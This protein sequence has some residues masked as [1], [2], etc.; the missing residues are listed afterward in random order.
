MNKVKWGV[1]GAGGIADRRTIPG[2][3]LADNAELT[4]IMEVNTALTEKLKQKYN[5]KYAYTD[6]LEL[7]ANP[8]IDAVYISSPV[9]YHKAQII[10]AAV[11]GKHI[12]CE[13]PIAMTIADC[14]EVISACENAGVLAATGFMMRYHGY[15]R[16]IKEMVADGALGQVVSARAQLTCWYPDIEGSWRQDKAQAGGGAL[17]DMGIHCIDLIEYITGSKTVKVGAFNDTKTFK[18]SV[19]DSSL[20]IIKLANGL[21]ASVDSNFNIPDDAAFCRL[22]IY[23]TK[24][25]IVA[26]GTIGQ[27]E[28]GTVRVVLPGDSIS[29][30][31]AQ[32]RER[33]A[34]TTLDVELGNM[35]AKEI[36]SFS[37][38]ILTGAPVEVPMSDS[39]HVQK[40]ITAA[41]ESSE[42][43]IF[44]DV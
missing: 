32:D 9:A 35:Y 31:A 15:H 21:T 18:Y 12:L 28:T 11:A 25:S 8:E 22:E 7:L 43:G 34:E 36:S 37:N 16:K 41:Y 4:A 13:K 10:A 6:H 29:Y 2:M 20:V 39:V 19:E 5:V 23:G 1:I 17:M 30:N 38:S 3:L 44:L 33:T 40:I 24:G 26:E 14:D 42:K 27:V